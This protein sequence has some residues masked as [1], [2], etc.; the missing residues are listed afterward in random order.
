MNPLFLTSMAAASTSI[1]GYA[2]VLLQR[3]VYALMAFGAG[4]LIGAALFDLLPSALYAAAASGSEKLLVFPIAGVGGLLIF[5]GAAACHSSA[6]HHRSRT[7]GKEGKISAALLIVHST[8]DGTAIFAA[9]TVSLQMG[10]LVGLGIVAHDVCDG[11][12]T[13]LLASGGRRPGWA[14]YGFLT[15]DAL[16]P[17]AGGLI[18]AHLFTISAQ[19]MMVFLSLAAGSFLFTAVFGLIPEA[20]Q[21]GRRAQLPWL[22]FAGFALVFCLSRLLGSLS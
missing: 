10:L 5:A 12:N 3:R 18:A 1:G 15:L 9:S 14:D 11:L 19:L 13:I 8:L 17:I 6:Y 16:A 22:G 21:L 20:W 4:V 2:A 7:G